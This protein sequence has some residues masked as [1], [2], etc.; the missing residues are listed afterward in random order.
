MLYFPTPIMCMG[1]AASKI[2][3]WITLA[4]QSAMFCTESRCTT[5]YQRRERK[6]SCRLQAIDTAPA[7]RKLV[8]ANSMQLTQ[9]LSKCMRRWQKWRRRE[10]VKLRR[11]PSLMKMKTPWLPRIETTTSLEDIATVAGEENEGPAGLRPALDNEYHDKEV[12]A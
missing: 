3:M 6:V 8:K 11:Y 12:A 10:N 2:T 7:Y 9:C 5:A 4:A 1:R